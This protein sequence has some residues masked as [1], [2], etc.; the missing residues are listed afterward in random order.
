MAFVRALCSLSLLFHYAMTAARVLERVAVS[1][2]AG[3]LRG[4]VRG[5]LCDSLDTND[6][7]SQSDIKRVQRYELLRTQ[8]LE[9]KSEFE[10][11]KNVTIQTC[12]CE[13]CHYQLKQL[14]SATEQHSD[15]NR[16]SH[17]RKR[18]PSPF[19][20]WQFKSLCAIIAVV[21]AVIVEDWSNI[22][23]SR[24]LVSNNYFVMEV[25]R[26]LSNCSMCEHVS[27]FIGLRNPTRAE[28]A[29]YAY[30]GS[31]LIVHNATASWAALHTFDFDFFKDVYS[32]TRGAHRAVEEECQFFPFRTGFASLR[33]VFNMPEERVRQLNGSRSWY[34]GW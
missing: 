32:N 18:P 23:A 11:R 34:I 15:A 3:K 17:R 1:L 16:I 22:V 31:P 29:R 2:A 6:N 21:A 28:F 5:H 12:S 4:K 13:N 33:D 7:L 10:L 24:C 14:T 19:D 27:G 9:L 8:L 30:S 25:T 26:P 20:N